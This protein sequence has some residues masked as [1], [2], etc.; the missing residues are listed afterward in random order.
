[1]KAI[2]ISQHNWCQGAAV[3]SVDPPFADLPQRQTTS[4]AYSASIE[5]VFSTFS[6][7]HNKISNR[8]GVQKAIK[9]V[10][11]YHMLSGIK[12]LEWIV[13]LS[14]VVLLFLYKK[15]RNKT[16]LQMFCL[17]FDLIYTMYTF[18]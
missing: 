9:L 13:K 10:F 14:Q 15:V 11:C 2:S 5:R 3:Y 6:F 7:V 18:L 8:L 17:Q 16:K 1:M 4:P 12:Y